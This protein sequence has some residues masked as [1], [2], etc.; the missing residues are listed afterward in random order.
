[1]HNTR[2][3]IRLYFDAPLFAG[4]EITLEAQAHYLMGVMRQGVGDRVE[5]FNGREGAW[6][7]RITAAAKRRVEVCV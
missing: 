3:K 1:M 4:A 5:L 6:A 7:A 2:P